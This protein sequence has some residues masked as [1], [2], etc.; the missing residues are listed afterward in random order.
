MTVKE[1]SQIADLSAPALALAGEAPAPSA[2]LDSLEKQQL[3]QDAIRFLAYKMAVDAGVKWACAC[4]RELQSPESKNEK[5]EALEA[6]EQWVKTPGDPTRWAA[7]EAAGKPKVRG[8]SKLVAMAVF[9]SGGSIT[10]PQAPET[11]PPP[12]LAQKMIAGSVDAT[13]LGYEPAK[14]TERYKRAVAMG[15]ALDQPGKA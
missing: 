7:K 2:Y 9:F 4:I 6:A 11:P 13:V 5:N 1:I 14:A 10:P 12:H 15:R 8:A 3:F